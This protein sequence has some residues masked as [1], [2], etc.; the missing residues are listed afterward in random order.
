MKPFILFMLSI[1]ITGCASTI[2]FPQKSGVFT[3]EATLKTGYK[4]RYTISIPESFCRDK[5]MPLILALHYGGEVTPFYAKEYL[6]IL[7]KPALKDLE[8]IIVAPDCPGKDWSNPESEKAVMELLN[9]ILTEYQIDQ[10][11]ILITGYSMGGIGTW[12]LA[13][14]HPEIFSAAVPMSAIPDLNE[15]PVVKDLPFFVIH[16]R[17]DELLSIDLL[18]KFIQMYKSKGGIIKFSEIDRIG[19]YD[20]YHFIKPLKE[21]VPWIQKMWIDSH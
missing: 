11:R 8:A 18:K 1:L 7:V 14:R 10:K 3:R 5:E 13:S 16:S 4:I 2:G 19:H 12:Y 21:A 9:S 17:N 6:N 20:T 15:T